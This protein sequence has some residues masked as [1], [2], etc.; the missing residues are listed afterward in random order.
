MNLINKLIKNLIG[1]KFWVVGIC[2]LVL[3]G[4]TLSPLSEQS[5]SAQSNQTNLSLTDKQQDIE[6]LRGITN[7]CIYQNPSFNPGREEKNADSRLYSL[8]KAGYPNEISLGEAVAVFN[9]FTQC[10][11]R[12]KTQPLLS[13]E[14][15]K[16]AI[17]DWNCAEEKDVDDKKF[18]ADAWKIAET[19]KMPKGSF[20]DF[21]RGTGGT[22]RVRGYKG[23]Y[24]NTWE[25]SLY[26]QLDKYRR[27]L[28]DV[29]EFTRSI[30]L[31][32]I[33]SEQIKD[34]Q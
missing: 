14:E 10:D 8:I 29:P 2:L 25:I 7:L 17:R 19:G 6:V 9:R 4:C 26:L 3:S 31:K 11:D 32:Y 12:S 24:V 34:V 16:A 23:Y 15:F 27:D 5:V 1:F 22:S 21:D 33:S 30:R 28:K 13:V 18:C 20:L